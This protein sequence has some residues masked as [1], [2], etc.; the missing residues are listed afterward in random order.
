MVDKFGKY[1]H[2]MA[3]S[4]PFTVFDVAMAYLSYIYKLLGIPQH[5]ISDR[6]RIFTSALWTELFRLADTQ[7]KMCSSYHPQTDGQTDRVAPRNGFDGLL[8]QSFGTILLTIW[9]WISH[10]LKYCMGISLGILVSV[11]FLKVSFLIWMNG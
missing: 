3:L 6:D 10:L 4:H 1:A 2:F 8:G 11:I 5:I 9:R 7:L